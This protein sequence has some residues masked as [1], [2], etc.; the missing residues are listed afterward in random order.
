MERIIV[1]VIIIIIFY[2]YHFFFLNFYRINIVSRW[3]SCIDWTEM[4]DKNALKQRVGYALLF[5]HTL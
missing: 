5:S 3:K 2:F 4:R 1:S